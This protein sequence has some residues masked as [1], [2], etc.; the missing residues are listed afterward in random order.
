M[1][2]FS[3][4]II[5]LNPTS[6][7]AHLLR[8]SA[9]YKYISALSLGT[10]YLPQHYPDKVKEFL[11]YLINNAKFCQHMRGKWFNSL[12]KLYYVYLKRY[13]EVFESKHF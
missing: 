1:L 4:A 11:L 6:K 9:R 2:I 12:V 3:E 5:D 7:P 8:F 10:K 13:E